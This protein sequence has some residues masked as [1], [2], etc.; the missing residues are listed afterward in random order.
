MC[1]SDRAWRRLAASVLVVALSAC[2][3]PLPVIDRVVLGASLPLSGSDTAAGIALRR[4]YGKAVDEANA[5]G[6]I[7]LAR[8]SRRVPVALTVLNDRGETPVAERHVATLI[9]LGVHVLLATHGDVRATAQALV[10]ERAGCAYVTNPVD[11]PGLPGSRMRWVVSVPASA[12]DVETRAYESAR[13]A[14]SMIERAGSPERHALR[15][16]LATQ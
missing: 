6:G 7:S 11:A 13:G 12:G 9:A 14:L 4:G 8:L 1:P 16:L 2:S 10:A 5:A 15:T 3:P